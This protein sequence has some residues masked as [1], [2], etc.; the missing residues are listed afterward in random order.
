MDTIYSSKTQIY[1]KR[2]EEE[3]NKIL[4]NY[5]Y[6]KEIFEENDNASID[7]PSAPDKKYT[8]K[9]VDFKINNI[10]RQFIV[11]IEILSENERLIIA[12][13]CRCDYH[14]TLIKIPFLFA[15]CPCCVGCL[16]NDEHRNR[17]DVIKK[18]R[19]YYEECNSPNSLGNDPNNIYRRILSVF[20]SSQKN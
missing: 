1:G 3:F 12:P 16:Q 19:N 15:P 5:E 2:T 8:A 4:E 18:T 7:V 6:K 17:Q 13:Y 11:A 9:T 20:S 10:N 14:M